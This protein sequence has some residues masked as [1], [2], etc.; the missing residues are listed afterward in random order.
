MNFLKKINLIIVILS[1]LFTTTA[2]SQK[3]YTL[4]G[5]V[6]DSYESLIGTTI[7]IPEI[8][9]GLM[10]DEKGFF[11]IELSPGIYTLQVSYLGYENQNIKVNLD[12]DQSLNITLKSNS[13]ELKELI[14]IQNSKK[15]DIR[16]P[17]MSVNK[18][19]VEEI[20]KMPVVLGETD[21]LKTILQLPGV[22]NAGEGAAGF[23]VRG[24]SAGQN[25]VLLDDAAI[26][27]SSHLFGFFSIF[28]A[29]AVKDLKLY[30]GGIPA[31]FGGRASSVLEVFQKSGN[32][33]EFHGTGGI[34]VISSRL[35][36]EGPIQKGKS[37]FLIAGRGSYAHLFL[38]LTDNDN[39]A[40]FYDINTKLSFD[41]NDKNKINFSGYFGRDIFSFTDIMKNSF[42]N[43]AATLNWRHLFTDNLTANLSLNT[44]QYTYDLDLD[45]IGFSWKSGI[46]SYQLKYDFTHDIDQ[47][48]Q[49]KYGLGVIAYNFDPGTIKPTR[50]DSSINYKKIDDK[51]ATEANIY[52][53]AEQKIGQH[54]SMNYGI[55]FS[56]FNA[57]G[58]GVEQIYEN[59]QPVLYDKTLGVYKMADPINIQTYSK[60]KSIKQ[61]NNLEPRL[62]IAYIIN[63]DQSVKASYNRMAQYIHLMS[64]TSAP[65]P[66]DIWTPSGR[67]LEPELVDQIA[68]GYFQNLSN[69]KYS[70]E[71]EVF[72]KKGKNSI[73]Y[74]D[75]A[76]LIGNDAIERVIL[77]GESQA[78]GLEFLLRKNTGQ[79]TGWI[80]YTLSRSEQRTPGRTI[81]EPGINNGEWYRTAYDKLH[82]LTATAIYDFNPKW[83]FSASFT[84]QSG[85]PITYPEG[86]YEYLGLRAPK[87]GERHANTMPAFH[88]LDV[89]ATYTPNPNS[90]KR[91]KSE[92]I[93]GIYNLYSRYNAASISFRE[94]EDIRGKNEAEKLSIFGLVPSVTYNF[95]F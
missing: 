94:N 48:L 17:E 34:G 23:N 53:E 37:S 46:K 15:T 42:G 27:S 43:L 10:T 93:F 89:S 57:T 14:I 86:Q 72:Y 18:L 12:S 47:S 1:F 78:Y 65:T 66:L 82:D 3:K 49:L 61:F 67:Y 58:K 85:R 52:I 56:N 25:L 4:K 6:Q 87:F 39:S 71:T 9:N 79:L 22:T 91:W 26:Y 7:Y 30:K 44:S 16:K 21:L 95:K 76:E 33:T 29:D 28:N 41:I 54:F 80:A 92:W 73:D 31:R 59:N 62:G 24:G 68:L 84:L 45:L 11:S 8:N 32:T 77:T 60:G 74:I 88:H 63:D 90:K 69:S 2:F 35:M 19:S 75:G 20:K 81:E 64:N 38:K 55:R 36:L 83:T 13:A 5:T 51:H 50:T 40:Y 70:L